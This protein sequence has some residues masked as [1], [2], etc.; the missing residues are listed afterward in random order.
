MQ[1]NEANKMLKILVVDDSRDAR[2]F[3]K[4]ILSNKFDCTVIEAENGQKALQLVAEEFPDLILLDIMMPIMG[5]YEFLKTLRADTSFARIPVIMC[6]AIGDKNTVA[7]FVEEGITDYILKPI[8][9]PS[10]YSK[11][12]RLIKRTSPNYFDL[13]LN[14]EG[15]GFYSIEPSPKDFFITF[16][17]IEGALEEDIYTLTI[18]NDDPRTAAKINDKSIINLPK[19]ETPLVL[20]FKFAYTKNKPI[21]IYYDFLV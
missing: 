21:I 15:V 20:T 19:H 8:N 11:I 7:S 5:G 1:Q 18:G 6:S 3:L 10:V 13:T 12:N 14:E 2:Q 16:R 4:L 17:S 9:L